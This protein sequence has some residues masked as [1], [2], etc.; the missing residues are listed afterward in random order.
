MAN[1]LT[2]QILATAVAGLA[3]WRT[4]GRYRQGVL[5]LVEALGWALLWAG[6]AYVF[7]QPEST[8]RLAAAVGIGRGAD[9]AVYAA[10]VFLLW[11]SFRLTVRLDRLDRQLTTVVRRRALDGDDRPEAR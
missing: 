3:I 9:L 10:V 8:S 11:A 1:L 2:L 5:S 7:W 4:Y 6:V